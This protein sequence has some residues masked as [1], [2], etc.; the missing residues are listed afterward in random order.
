MA[1]EIWRITQFA[2]NLLLLCS[3]VAPLR[4]FS[5]ITAAKKRARAQAF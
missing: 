3:K 4:E 1:M 5:L 2:L